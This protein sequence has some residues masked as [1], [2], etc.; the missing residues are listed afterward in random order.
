MNE[1]IKFKNKQKQEQLLSLCCMLGKERWRRCGLTLTNGMVGVIETNRYIRLVQDTQDVM[2]T[3]RRVQEPKCVIREGVLE[4][5][6]P[7]WN[8]KRWARES[9]TSTPSGRRVL[10]SGDGIPRS[11]GRKERGSCRRSTGCA[12]LDY[13]SIN[14]QALSPC[15]LGGV[16]WYATWLW[17]E[18]VTCFGHC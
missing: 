13:C 5:A 14:I 17:A 11:R 1:C 7:A 8:L 10:G 6:A 15:L 4:E 9:D 16:Y 12:R 18:N 2:G 3:W